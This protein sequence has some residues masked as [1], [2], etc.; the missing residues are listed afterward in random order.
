M[1]TINSGSRFTFANQ[2]SDEFGVFMVTSLGSDSSTG[3]D[4]TRSIV[5]SKTHY[6]D[7]FNL[8][9]LTE[10]N[11]LEFERVIIKMDESFINAHEERVL[12]KWLLKNKREWFQ[13]VQDDLFDI[14]YYGVI[15]KVEKIDVGGYTG[16]LKFYFVA[17]SSHAWSSLN[18]H[19]YKSTTELNE[20]ITLEFDYDEY[21]LYPQIII[22]SLS[23]TPQTI[24]IKNNTTNETISIKECTLNEEI[25]VDCKE[26][27]IKSSNN[28]VLIDSWNRH[29]ISMVEGKNDI[30]LNGNFE[31][32]IRYRLPIRVGA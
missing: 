18:K 3:A 31:L 25:L 28:R 9:Y 15:T 7:T 14:F 24:V 29:M 32:E 20:S 12:K 21:V 1:A 30:T 5:T 23:S 22:K 10:D 16:G 4:E 6:K 27:R 2:L 26:D 8:H 13:V 19:D 11:P 17:D